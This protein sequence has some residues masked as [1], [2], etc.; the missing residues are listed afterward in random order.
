MATLIGI[1]VISLFIGLVGYVSWTRP[2]R[3]NPPT[4]CSL[5][6]IRGAQFAIGR[7]I[8]LLTV[9]LIG[10][11][12]QGGVLTGYSVGFDRGDVMSAQWEWPSD[13]F[14]SS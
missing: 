3:P 5:G 12:V 4:G 13:W 2:K 10:M 14:S 9:G 8:V 7:G 6:S 11:I 1:G